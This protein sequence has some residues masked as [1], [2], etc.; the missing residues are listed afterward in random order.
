M[1]PRLPAIS[2][3]ECPWRP[4]IRFQP[5]GAHMPR[6]LVVR[7]LGVLQWKRS[8][9]WQRPR[10]V[11][12]ARCYTVGSRGPRISDAVRR[13][14][15]ESGRQGKQ[16]LS[17]SVVCPVVRAASRVRHGAP[18]PRAIESRLCSLLP[19]PLPFVTIFRS[20]DCSGPYP[21]RDCCSSIS[22]VPCG[23]T[24]RACASAPVAL[25]APPARCS[26]VLRTA[27][28]WRG[29]TR[30]SHRGTG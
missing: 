2:P 25:E 11:E 9:S 18:T 20:G 4:P 27:M 1:Q 10:N 14:R 24:A 23:T 30:S 12:R 29:D 17:R 16:R 22:V 15:G 26:D 19:A 28:P 3:C 13:C 21:S 5:T 6:N 8:Q 7:R